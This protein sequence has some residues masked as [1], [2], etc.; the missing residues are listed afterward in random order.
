[1]RRSLLILLLAGVL[2]AALAG[3]AFAE[4]GTITITVS[5]SRDR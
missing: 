3:P 2:A 5:R 1:M 4:H